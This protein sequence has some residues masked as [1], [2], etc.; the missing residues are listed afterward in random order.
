MGGLSRLPPMCQL[1][2]RCL[3]SEGRVTASLSHGACLEPTQQCQATELQ[4]GRCRG[5]TALQAAEQPSA[6]PACPAAA[7]AECPCLWPHLEHI[8]SRVLPASPAPGVPASDNALCADP[9]SGQACH[10][11]QVTHGMGCSRR[12]LLAGSCSP[13]RQSRAPCEH[14]RLQC[15][16]VG[17]L[18][19]VR[20][21]AATCLLQPSHVS[22]RATRPT[23]DLDHAVP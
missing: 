21:G 9:L 22:T 4:L 17:A 20:L 8:V 2:D 14:E 23:R 12:C 7:A 19:Q 5:D 6:S 10:R 18:H 11:E 16:A 3:G 13:C 15:S 1:P